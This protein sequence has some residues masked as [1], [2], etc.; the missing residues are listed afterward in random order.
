MIE[1]I[2]L[3]MWERQFLDSNSVCPATP[4]MSTLRVSKEVEIAGSKIRTVRSMLNNTPLEFC[5][6]FPCFQR[7]WSCVVVLEEYLSKIS[8]R[9]NSPERLR[10]GFNSINVK[11]LSQWFHHAA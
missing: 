5:D 3:L 8:L 9:S 4:P 10:K 1:I 11:N 6:Y 7:I 2:L